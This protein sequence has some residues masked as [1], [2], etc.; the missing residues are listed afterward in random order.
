MITQFRN[1]QE[2]SQ[3]RQKIEAQIRQL[4]VALEKAKASIAQ[5]RERYKAAQ[6]DEWEYIIVDDISGTR[7]GNLGKSGWELA[8]VAP[9]RVSKDLL[10]PD[11][12]IL[13]NYIFKRK[14]VIVPPEVMDQIN[15][16]YKIALLERQIA[17]LE[18]TWEHLT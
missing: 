3:S 6:S 7:L 8:G 10:G 2:I 12:D 1:W 5:E 17:D 4:E 14:I 9:S 16:K 11:A 18:K 13:V 15:G